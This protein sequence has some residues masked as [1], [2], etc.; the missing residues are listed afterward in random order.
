MATGLILRYDKPIKI[1]EIAQ[2]KGLQGAVEDEW[3]TKHSVLGDIVPR[4]TNN[5]TIFCRYVP[6]VENTM[7]VR[8]QDGVIYR[9]IAV[10]EHQMR[11]NILRLE[12][13]EQP[14]CELP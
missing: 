3:Q 1:E 10:A 6:G 9:I 7:R 13:L 5:F 14:R 11:R 2:S 12:C 4:G 8:T